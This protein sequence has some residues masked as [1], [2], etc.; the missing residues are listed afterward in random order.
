MRAALLCE[1]IAQ[2]AA[3]CLT[4]WQAYSRPLPYG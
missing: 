2:T 4:L 1:S 3:R